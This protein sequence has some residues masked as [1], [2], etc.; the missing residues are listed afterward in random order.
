MYHARFVLDQD[1]TVPAVLS[2]LDAGCRAA[3]LS[4]TDTEMA[5]SRA[6]DVLKAL[7]ESGKAVASAGGQF[8]ASREIVTDQ[9]AID[10]VVTFET[11]PGLLS[12]IWK[13]LS[14]RG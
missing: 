12:R 1:G 10:V 3:G 9:A 6:R 8:R 5:V 13:A 2:K 14:G 4:S 7:V 11:S